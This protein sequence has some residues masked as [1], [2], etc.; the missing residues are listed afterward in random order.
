MNDDRRHD[1]PRTPDRDAARALAA[2]AR[3]PRARPSASAR[4]HARAAFLHGTEVRRLPDRR[5][6]SGRRW[7]GVLVAALAATLA[8]VW[9]GSAPEMDWVVTDVVAP[10]GVT[11]S[12]AGDLAPGARVEAGAVATAAG[13]E[14]ELQLGD[15]LR[16]RL[17]PGTSIEL[18]RAPGR[19][20][21]DD[22][23]LDLASGEIYGTTGDNA[24]GFDLA[25]ATE[26]LEARLT[27]TTFA[28]FRTDSTSCVCLWEGGI[29]VTPLVG[30]DAPIALDEQQRVWIFKDGSAPEVSPLDAMEI[31]KLQMTRDAGLAETD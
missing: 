20:F 16:F 21:G 23:R 25:F 17:L 7:S 12:A 6:R 9:F 19:W 15:R 30:P 4:E 3:V 22:R 2:L 10:E 5:A 28:V 13:S 26:E 14:L 1:D 29:L 8:V 27:G 24:L 11:V 31:M 18:P